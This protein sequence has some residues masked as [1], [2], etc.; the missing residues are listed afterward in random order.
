MLA[1]INL[2]PHPRNT[3]GTSLLSQYYTFKRRGVHH[4]PDENTVIVLLLLNFSRKGL[5]TD[6]TM[7]PPRE[8]APEMAS[9]LRFSQTWNILGPFQIG[10]RGMQNGWIDRYIIDYT[11]NVLTFDA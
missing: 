10:T 7:N 11:H 1:R 4:L 5:C 8:H 6:F 2:T 3:F 9:R